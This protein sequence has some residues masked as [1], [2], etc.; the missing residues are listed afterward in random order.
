MVVVVPVSVIE[1]ENMVMTIK[2]PSANPA[3]LNI[4]DIPRDTLF[5]LKMAAAAEH[6]TVKELVLELVDSKIQDME[7]KGVLPKGK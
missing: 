4:R 1:Q 3:H 5:R 7:K 2:Q 6:K